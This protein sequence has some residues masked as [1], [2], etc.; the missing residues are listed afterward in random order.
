VKNTLKF[1]AA[2]LFAAGI[3]SAALAQHAAGHQTTMDMPAMQKMM[4]D[5]MPKATDAPSTKEFKEAQIKMMKATPQ[6]SGNADVDLVR[7][8]IPHHQSAID[9]AK[10]QLAHGKDPQIRALAEK[11]IKDQEKEIADMEEWLKKNAK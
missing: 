7:Q 3:G 11:I 10:V 5:M 4:E 9:M 2:T 1:L 8:M 6:F